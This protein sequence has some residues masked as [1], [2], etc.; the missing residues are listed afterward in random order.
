MGTW[1]N[2]WFDRAELAVGVHESQKIED[3]YVNA[4]AFAG[5]VVGLIS[6]LKINLFAFEPTLYFSSV[7][8]VGLIMSVYILNRFTRYKFLARLIFS[9]LAVFIMNIIF[10]YNFGSNGPVL[11]I[12]PIILLILYFIWTGFFQ[13][14]F[15]ILL[16]VNVLLFFYL[17]FVQSDLINIPDY[18]T[19]KDR[20]EDNYWSFLLFTIVGVGMLRIVRR[21]YLRDKR[22]AEQADQLKSSFLANM[23]HEIRTPMNTILGFSQLLEEEKSPEK[24][25]KFAA[26]I[27]ENG[28]SLLRLIDDIIDISRIEAGKLEIK[29]AEGDLDILM[30]SLR[31][32]FQ[33]ILDNHQ[34]DE[35][36]LIVSKPQQGT[37]VITDYE[38]LR[39]ILSN[40]IH[41]A[42]KYTEQGSITF[43]YSVSFDR[44]RFFVKDTGSGIRREEMDR[45]FERFHKVEYDRSRKIQK[46][47]G[48]GLALSMN[49][50]RLLGGELLVESEYGIGS[51]FYFTIPLLLAEARTHKSSASS[52]KSINTGSLIGMKFMI[53]D[54][55]DTSF[56]FLEYVLS[57]LGVTVLRAVD[58]EEAVLMVTT[59]HDINLVFMDIMLP[60]MNGYD[61]TR[62]IKKFVPD[63][64]VIAQTALAMDM[65][66]QKAYDAGCDGC[67]S[68]PLQISVVLE[69]INRVLGVRNSHTE[70]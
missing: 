13:W 55:D 67:L 26:I 66:V 6:L 11:Y 14:F 18:P 70:E 17:E 34:V 64:P 19:E 29:E 42:V 65:D 35:V 15:L 33:Q 7:L 10:F 40:L 2:E 44:I 32:T 41:N 25:K 45:I 30:E 63:L 58:G 54:D 53:V 23:S 21:S 38:R 22:L 62:E 56:Q 39:Q 57:G 50:V 24:R 46:G 36:K 9:I 48:I 3:Q 52:A 51:E 1:L 61:A 37:R 69:E 5:S 16:G 49:L 4:V 47:T 59:I 20:I 12:V 8:G 31:G 68:K 60:R 27:N 43:G 28:K